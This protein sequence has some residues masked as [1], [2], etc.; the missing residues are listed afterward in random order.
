[1]EFPRP[2]TGYNCCWNTTR[3]TWNSFISLGCRSTFC[4]FE[5]VFCPCTICT[6]EWALRIPRQAELL[7][8]ILR[9]KKE[10][11]RKNTQG[12]KC[13]ARYGMGPFSP[14]GGLFFLGIPEGRMRKKSRLFTTGWEWDGNVETLLLE[15]YDGKTPFVGGTER[16]GKRI[17]ALGEMT[18]KRVGTTVDRE[19]S[20]DGMGWGYTNSWR[21]R[22]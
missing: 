9:S 19:H 15:G 13:T 4:L 12:A 2:S 5:R 7:P 10:Q 6:K 8:I 21:N 22:T 11:K 16:D 14:P 3:K 20:R 1:M 18:G 17:L